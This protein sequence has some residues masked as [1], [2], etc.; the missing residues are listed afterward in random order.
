[1]GYLLSTG[2]IF[3][4]SAILASLAIGF[5][6]LKAVIVEVLSK[7]KFIASATDIRRNR[8]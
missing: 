3:F 7:V 4:I 8:S 2:I 5:S 6:F 1:M